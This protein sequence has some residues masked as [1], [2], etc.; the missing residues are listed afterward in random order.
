MCP[1]SKPWGITYNITAN[2]TFEFHANVSWRAP[3]NTYERKITGY[4]LIVGDEGDELDG[5]E[6]PSRVNQYSIFKVHFSI[7][8]LM[9]N[10]LC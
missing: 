2:L 3:N 1:A 4:T 8:V 9:C 7:L 6:S 5:V 10:V